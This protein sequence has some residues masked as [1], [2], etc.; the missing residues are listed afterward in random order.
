[1]SDQQLLEMLES[2]DLRGMQ[3]EREHLLPSQC[4]SARRQ[5]ESV[6]LSARGEW[7]STRCRCVVVWLAC[8]AGFLRSSSFRGCRA[9]IDCHFDTK[10][11]LYRSLSLIYQAWYTAVEGWCSGY[12][13]TPRLNT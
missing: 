13:G 5:R 8:W 12:L 10:V 9:A 1:M 4:P 6:P 2:Q 11:A 3:P 7:S